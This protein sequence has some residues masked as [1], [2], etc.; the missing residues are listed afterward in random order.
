MEGDSICDDSGDITR[1]AHIGL[2]NKMVK[3][4]GNDC[5]DDQKLELAKR[6]AAEDLT[7]ML[8][9]HADFR[10]DKEGNVEGIIVL[11]DTNA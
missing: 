1:H 8:M 11:P 4:P 3:H 6:R 2:Q 10:V 5:R 7:K 9:K